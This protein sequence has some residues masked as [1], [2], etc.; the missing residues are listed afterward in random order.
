MDNHLR[1]SKKI[2]TLPA[3]RR[4]DYFIKISVYNGQIL[5][6]ASHAIDLEK[7]HVR[8]FGNPNDVYNFI[9]MIIEKDNYE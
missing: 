4:G 7:V 5:L 2:V 9:D 6:V 8:L 1:V 3:V